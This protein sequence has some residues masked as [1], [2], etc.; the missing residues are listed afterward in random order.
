MSG[1]AFRMP[2]D[3]G[4]A[5]SIRNIVSIHGPSG[6]GVT[7]GLCSRNVARTYN[8]GKHQPHAAIFPAQRL[9]ITQ[10]HLNAVTGHDV[11]Y[12]S[13]EDVGPLLF[14]QGSTLTFRFG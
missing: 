10:A 13:G 2:H 3:W 9:Y 7:G 14:Q 8:H 4:N 6:S 1:A 5:R 11:G 12:G